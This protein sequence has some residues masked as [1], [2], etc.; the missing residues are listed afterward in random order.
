M[1]IFEKV[2]TMN[3]DEFCEFLVDIDRFPNSPCYVCEYDEGLNCIS[4]VKCTEEYRAKVY[5]EYF[6]KE[7]TNP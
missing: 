1:T 5:K 3:V 4:P 2:K 6:T 7:R